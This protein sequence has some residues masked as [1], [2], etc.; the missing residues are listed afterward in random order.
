MVRC[1]TLLR[2]ECFEPSIKM[3]AATVHLARFRPDSGR[4]RDRVGR[5]GEVLV[6]ARI[7]VAGPLRCVV[8]EF[9][10]A[11]LR[12]QDVGAKGGRMFRRPGSTRTTVLA[13]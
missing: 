4:N 9:L 2:L 13:G 6:K 7:V 1:K 8:D 12:P 10:P 5:V 11:R 3:P